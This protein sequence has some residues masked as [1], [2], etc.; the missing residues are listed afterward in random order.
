MS[1]QSSKSSL[2]P[3]DVCCVVDQF[4]LAPANLISS[5]LPTL[6]L[7]CFSCGQPVCSKCSSIR[8]YY[9]YGK[10]RLC[11]ICQIEYDDSDE[12]VMRRLNKLAGYK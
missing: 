3:K 10:V 12:V 8:K 4:C 5:H 2:K 9:D 11:N 7:I 6:R 1:N